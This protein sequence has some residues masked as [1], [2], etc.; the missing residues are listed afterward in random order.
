[1]TAPLFC[2][3][4]CHKA[5]QGMRHSEGSLSRAGCVR[6]QPYPC[7]RSLGVRQSDCN[8]VRAQSVRT[9]R[10]GEVDVDF[11][12]HRIGVDGSVSAIDLNAGDRVNQVVRRIIDFQVILTAIC[13]LGMHRNLRYIDPGGTS[14]PP[15][16][17]FQALLYISEEP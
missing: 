17:K 2:R 5:A 6:V 10:V 7:S 1:M 3:G 15:I 16:I 14:Q 9:R 12:G 4:A 11:P 8:V 13:S